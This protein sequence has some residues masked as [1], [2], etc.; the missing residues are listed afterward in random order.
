M[1][2]LETITADVAV[3]AATQLSSILPAGLINMGFRTGLDFAKSAAASVATRPIQNVLLQRIFG[4]GSDKETL[5]LL[6][7]QDDIGFVYSLHDQPQQSSKSISDSLEPI[8]LPGGRL[9]HAVLHIRN[10]NQP[11]NVQTTTT[12]DRLHNSNLQ[13][14]RLEPTLHF[15]VDLA[16][17]D[18]D[19]HRSGIGGQAEKF[20][21]QMKTALE[22]LNRQNVSGPLC[23]VALT[24]IL[25]NE[26]HAPR[27]LETVTGC[28]DNMNPEVDVAVAVDVDSTWHLATANSM[29][30]STPHTVVCSICRPDGH[31][32]KVLS[33]TG[34]DG[35]NELLQR[36]V[37][38]ALY[39]YDEQIE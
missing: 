9:P 30:V 39:R 31:I 2:K 4:E 25:A 18:T 17:S 37:Q 7:P 6:Y 27:V 23:T 14:K 8:L 19:A 24:L 33:L 12:H 29:T 15:F 22:T 20:V 32:A 26:D 3:A 35:D 16:N 38:R 11:N 5:R 21:I 10:S 28:V 1:S 36:E 34:S 13:Q